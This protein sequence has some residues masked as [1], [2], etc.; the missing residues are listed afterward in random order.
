MDDL[1]DDHRA[2]SSKPSMAATDNLSS[3]LRQKIQ[4]AFRVFD[5][6]NNNTVDTREIGTIVR[7]LGFCPSEAE[8]QGILREMEDPQQSGYIMYDRYYPVM[9]KI[10]VQHQY[11]LSDTKELLTAFKLLDGKGKGFFSVEE[12]RRLF[13]Q[14]GEPFA[15]DE[16]DELLNAAVT[17]NTREI[18]YETFVHNL[19][20]DEEQKL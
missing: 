7:S 6:E 2:M 20:V 5:H 8:L 16:L 18:H 12:I 14:Y 11:Q 10:I 19:T 4:D 17:P 1:D 13:T 3:D 9:S 15:Q